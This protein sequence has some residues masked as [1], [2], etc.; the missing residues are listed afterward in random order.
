MVSFHG[1]LIKAIKRPRLIWLSIWAFGR[2]WWVDRHLQ[3]LAVSALQ[4]RKL[5][6][7]KLL[8]Q[9]LYQEIQRRVAVIAWTASHHPC[10]PQC[11]HRSLV[12]YLW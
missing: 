1:L 5:P 7:S 6:V 10:R 12:L 11:L 8:S 2:L 3:V 4:E 9:E